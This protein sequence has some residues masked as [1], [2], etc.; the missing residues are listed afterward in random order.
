MNP[1]FY[2]C[3]TILGLSLYNY[4]YTEM[5]KTV[6]KWLICTTVGGGSSLTFKL[7]WVKFQ[8]DNWWWWWENIT[9][10][11]NLIFLFERLIFLPIFYRALY[12]SLRVSY[13]PFEVLH[14]LVILLFLPIYSPNLRLLNIQELQFKMNLIWYVTWKCLTLFLLL[15]VYTEN[16]SCTGTIYM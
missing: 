14:I 7:L 4:I 8:D 11:E 13:F 3:K 5:S 12:F 10:A 1:K 9:S 6:P 16:I 15:Q 2:C